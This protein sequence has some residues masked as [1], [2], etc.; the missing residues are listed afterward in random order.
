[1]SSCHA[2]CNVAW[3]PFRVSEVYVGWQVGGVPARE[4][5]EQ[6]RRGA[7]QRLAQF[8]ETGAP[9]HRATILPPCYAIYTPFCSK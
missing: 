2:D 1:M 7:P 5:T 9:R 6:S 4:P 3:L 8:R